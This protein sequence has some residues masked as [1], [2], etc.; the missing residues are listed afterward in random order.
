MSGNETLSLKAAAAVA[1]I[2]PNE[3]RHTAQRGEI[4]AVLRGDEWLFRRRDVDEWMQRHL[5]AANE[6]DLRKC[7]RSMADEHRRLSA[8]RWRIAGD[9]L[10]EDCIE[11]ALDARTKAGVVRD[12]TD[13]AVRSGLVYD[14]ES[15][16]RELLARE[17]AASTAIGEGVAFLHPRYHAPFMFEDSFIVYARGARP[18][19][20]GAPDGAPT[21]HFFLVCATDRD[22]HLHAL[23][24]LAV[25]AHG[26]GLVEKLDAAESAADVISAVR[27]AEEEY[28]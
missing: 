20:F 4:D 8:D 12:M 14:E 25:L 5:L 2:D 23:A 21:R 15:L 6:K 10:R 13:I 28:A 19:F 27:E 3:L 11:L 22:L 7:H 17:E 18:V 16:F 1:H 24:R 9:L 26:A